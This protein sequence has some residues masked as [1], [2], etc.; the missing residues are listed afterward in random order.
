MR[1]WRM[2]LVSPEAPVKDAILAIQN[3]GYQIALVADADERLLGTVTD[4]DVRRALLKGVNMEHPVAGIAN[5]DPHTAAPDTPEQELLAILNRYVVRQLPLVS[6]DG[7]LR[8]V[9][10]IDLLKERAAR[11]GNPVVLM[12]GGLGRRL[13]PLTANTPKP[14][15]SVG[16]KPLLE[17]ILEGFIQHGFQSYYISVNYLAESIIDHFGKGDRWDI[18]ITYLRENEPL[19]TAGALRLLPERPHMPIIVMNG[20]LITRVNFHELLRYHE[21]TGALGTMCVRE[22]DME[23]PFGVVDIRDNRIHAIDEKPVHRFFVNAGIY[24]ISPDALDLIPGDGA[25]DMTSLFDA[26]TESGSHAAAFPIHE[27]WLDIGRSD[28]FERANIDAMD[29]TVR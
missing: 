27:Y 1:D 18:D 10:H 12:A 16:G 20:D 23:V 5:R 9:A 8:G 11:P 26:I 15:L 13:R 22:Y 3:S 6:A 2:T 24:V 17:G 19:G 21:E 14:L 28:D 25:F 4:G 7:K 29:G